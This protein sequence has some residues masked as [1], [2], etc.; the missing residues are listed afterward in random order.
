MSWLLLLNASSS[1][2]P[3]PSLPQVHWLA[4]SPLLSSLPSSNLTNS[5]ISIRHAT[6]FSLLSTIFSPLVDHLS[7][8]PVL[9]VVMLL[10]MDRM[11]HSPLSLTHERDSSQKHT[12]TAMNQLPLSRF[13]SI[14]ATAATRSITRRLAL[15]QAFL[16]FTLS[17]C[18]FARKIKISETRTKD[19][20]LSQNHYLA[21]DRSHSVDSITLT[22]TNTTRAS[23]P[24]T[25]AMHTT[26]TV[27]AVV[28]FSVQ[29]T[30]AGGPVI[31]R[32]RSGVRL[33]PQSGMRT[34]P[35]PRTGV[36]TAVAPAPAFVVV[37]APGAVAVI[38][39]A[40]ARTVP[41]I[42]EAVG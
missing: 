16:V 38:V 18:P 10:C 29:R 40:S 31:T 39:I 20:W 36:P 5:S 13:G 41:A 24:I 1:Q 11:T 32:V 14:T 21:G 3:S 34:R 19:C 23:V 8:S 4:H 22:S 12:P 27:V 6:F 35:E 30:R 2:P 37:L 17:L 28:S 25:P 42:F 15:A 33:G 26:R 9:A 7:T